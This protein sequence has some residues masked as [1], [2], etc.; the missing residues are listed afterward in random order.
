[1]LAESCT[2]GLVAQSLS[3]I[4]GASRWLCGSAVVYRNETKS[5]WLGID[6]RQ[7]ADPSAGPV[8]APTAA[9]MCAGLLRTTPEA[10][11]AVSVTGHLGPDAP[12]ALDGLVYIGVQWREGSQHTADVTAIRLATQPPAD[13]PFETLRRHRQHEAAGLVLQQ[14]LVALQRHESSVGSATL[15]E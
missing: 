7:L 15:P 3:C 12:P 11:L 9:D 10:D 8:S 4:P 5:A 6:P 2:A 13:S 14:L 1:M